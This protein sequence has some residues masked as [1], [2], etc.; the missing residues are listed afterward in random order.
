MRILS[1]FL[2]VIAAA[3]QQNVAAQDYPVYRVK[4]DKPR[5]GS[6]IRKVIAGPLKVAINRAYSDLSPSEK[7]QVRANYVD[8]PEH[9]EPPFP[10]TGLQEL[11]RPIAAGQQ[12]LLVTG[13]LSLIGLVNEFGQVVQVK[14]IGSPSS[15]M[16]EFAGKVMLLTEFKPGVCA[17]R[18]CVMEF[19]LYLRFNVR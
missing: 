13:E 19:L 7:Q 9:D 17:G 16:A 4:E 10:K 1:C 15:E 11:I 8:L 6:N 14:I 2:V 3:F 12:K 5:A 18:P